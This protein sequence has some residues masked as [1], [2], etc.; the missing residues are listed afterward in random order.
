MTM[1][2]LE[3]ESPQER[4]TEGWVQRRKDFIKLGYQEKNT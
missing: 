1:C 3:W 4:G 2:I